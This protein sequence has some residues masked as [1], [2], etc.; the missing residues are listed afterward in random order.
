[1][2]RSSIEAPQLIVDDDVVDP[3]WIEQQLLEV[4]ELLLEPGRNALVM[5]D[6]ILEAELLVSQLRKLL[7][8]LCAIPVQ[9]QELFALCFVRL[10]VGV[11]KNGR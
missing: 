11:P 5:L 3:L 1:M 6:T 4:I 2:S 10:R 9:L 7:L 8:Q